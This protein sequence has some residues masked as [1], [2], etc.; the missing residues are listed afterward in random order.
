MDTL[1]KIESIFYDKDAKVYLI[2][3]L[4]ANLFFLWYNARKI[5]QPSLSQLPNA[6]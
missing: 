3:I 1:K 2:I 5:N 4:I 6:S